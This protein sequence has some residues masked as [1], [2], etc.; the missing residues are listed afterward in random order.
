MKIIINESSASASATDE[1]IVRVSYT[2]TKCR[3]LTYL[4]IQCKQNSS[5]KPFM[6]EF[7]GTLEK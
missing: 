5:E 6:N 2:H 1:L 4:S 7:T 3:E